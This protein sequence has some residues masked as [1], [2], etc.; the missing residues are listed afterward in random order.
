MAHTHTHPGAV[1]RHIKRDKRCR[2]R[3]RDKYTRYGFFFEFVRFENISPG[4]DGSLGI[5]AHC[6]R[7]ARQG[8]CLTPPRLSARLKSSLTPSLMSVSCD[9]LETDCQAWAAHR[10]EM[11]QHKF[12]GKDPLSFF[13]SLHTHTHTCPHTHT[14]TPCRVK[15]NTFSRVSQCRNK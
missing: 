3:C 5:C 2:K 11:M 1:K 8:P 4:D 7:I 15:I 14:H 10:K 12:Q 13:L 9:V 6:I